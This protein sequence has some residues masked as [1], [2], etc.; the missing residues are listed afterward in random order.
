MKSRALRQIAIAV[1]ALSVT[2]AGLGAQQ[3]VSGW[4]GTDGIGSHGV[5]QRQDNQFKAYYQKHATIYVSTFPPKA[6]R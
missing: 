2:V 1:I 6:N 3:L 5:C 4:C